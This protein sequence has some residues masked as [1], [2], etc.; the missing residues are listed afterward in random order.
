[1]RLL[2]VA[3]AVGLCAADH[4]RAAEL[5]LAASLRG[6]VTES[7]TLAA[8]AERQLANKARVWAMRD[9]FMPTNYAFLPDGGF[10][11]A[12]GY[13]SFRIHRYDK[14]AKWVSAFG[15]VGDGKGTFNT[16]HGARD[17]CVQITECSCKRIGTC[18]CESENGF[19][20]F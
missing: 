20:C 3:T 6:S 17:N 16:P 12:D 8:D 9:A 4:A 10:F 1:M 13:G 15:G 19:N 11:L 18:G 14:D 5:D 7:P 2:L